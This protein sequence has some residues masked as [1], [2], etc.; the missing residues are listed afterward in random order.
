MSINSSMMFPYEIIHF[1]ITIYA[2]WVS[3][4]FHRRIRFVKS[5][6]NLWIAS[7]ARHSRVFSVLVSIKLSF[8]GIWVMHSRIPIPNNEAFAI[9]WTHTH[10][11]FPPRVQCMYSTVE[12]CLLQMKFMNKWWSVDS[13]LPMSLV[14][15]INNRIYRQFTC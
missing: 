8:L 15:Q 9:F 11:F 13:S 6:K 4:H 2:Q 12:L 5:W 10:E 1:R 14:W 7:F 3:L